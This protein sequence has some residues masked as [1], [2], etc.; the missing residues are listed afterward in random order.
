MSERLPQITGVVKAQIPRGLHYLL[1]QEAEEQGVS[2]NDWCAYKIAAGL[3]RCEAERQRLAN[4][5]GLHN[6]YRYPKD[7]WT[8]AARL[9]SSIPN[10][11]REA[12]EASAKQKRKQNYERR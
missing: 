6:R 9:D 10:G 3:A 4:R 5:M 12:S 2:F 8:R 11:K 1:H 7:F